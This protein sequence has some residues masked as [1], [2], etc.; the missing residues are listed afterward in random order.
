MKEKENQRVI[1]TKRMLKDG[2]LQLM[3][4]KSM[5]KITV[6]ELCRASGINRVTF[7]NHYATPSDVLTEIGDDLVDELLSLLKEKQTQLHSTL[8]EQVEFACEYLRQNKKIAKLV[9][10]NNTPESEFAMKLFHGQKKWK[11]VSDKLES[12]YGKDGKD[13]LFTFIIHGAYCMIS[14]WLLDD[15][16]MTPKEIGNLVCKITIGGYPV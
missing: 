11:T 1:V 5:Q 7:Y 3:E 9:F 12:I 16:Q 15:V 4:T 2:L 8:Q 6:T 10:Q 13:L 14:K